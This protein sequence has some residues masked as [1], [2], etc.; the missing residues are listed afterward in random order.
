MKTKVKENNQQGRLRIAR[1]LWPLIVLVFSLAPPAS[2]G[3]QFWTVNGP[4]GG[5]IEALA[6][7]PQNPQVLYAGGPAGVYK[8]TSAGERWERVKGNIGVQALAIDP[9]TSQ[10][11]YAGGGGIWRS[12][13]GGSTW[14][15]ASTGLTNTNIWALVVDPVN[16]QNLYAGTF[17]GG[18]FKSIDQ[19][20]SWAAI[21]NGLPAQS[22]IALAIDPAN[23]QNLY[24]GTLC[25]G[26][27]RSADGGASWNSV[28]GPGLAGK[29][30]HALEMD[31]LSPQVVYAGTSEGTVYKSADSGST[32]TQL[33]TAGLGL[34]NLYALAVDPANSSTLYLASGG[35]GIYK[36]TD[37]GASW[38]GMSAGIINTNTYA[39]AL[40]PA[41]QQ[42]I[43]TSTLGAGIFKSTDGAGSWQAAN[44]GINNATVRSLVAQP[45]TSGILYASSFGGVAKSTDGGGSWSGA[46][47]GLEGGVFFSLAIDP[48]H[49]Q[50]LY[51]GA[52][53]A[54]AP[55][56]KTTDGGNTWSPTG[57]GA[58]WGSSASPRALAVDPINP[59]VV[60]AGGWGSLFK[61]VDGG[62][63]WAASSSGIPL[64]GTYVS[65]LAVDPANPQ[66]LY[67]GLGDGG[68]GATIAN[69]GAY[70]SLDGGNTWAPLTGLPATGVNALI[71]DPL[72]T[73]ILYAG[74]GDA[75]H[76]PRGVYRSSDGGATWS[77]CSAGLT[78]SVVRALAIDPANPQ[79]LYAGGGGVFMSKDRGITWT[80]LS[81]GLTN[82]DIRTLTVDPGHPQTVYAGT[83]GGGVFAITL[84]EPPA[85]TP[86]TLADTPWPM[87]GHDLQHTGRSPFKGP[88]NP[89]IA[90]CFKTGAEVFSSPA[91]GSDGSIYVGS[92]DG[93]LY[94]LNPDGSRQWAYA[95]GGWVDSSPAIGSDGSIYV[96]SA[97]N[98][99][100]L[101][102]NGAPVWTSPA[103]V[104]LSSPALSR[105]GALYV[106]GSDVY[107]I[108]TSGVSK[109]RFQA[110]REFT[111]SPAV[112]SDGTVYVGTEGGTLLALNPD[113]SEKWR[114]TVSQAFN[115]SPALTDDGTV[116]VGS[117]DGGLYALNGD[118]T[119]KW[120]FAAN[121]G[122]F[123]SPA[124]GS[125]G[126]IYVGAGGLFAI[127]PAG[128]LKW[129][130]PTGGAT[131]S[132][133][134]ID[135]EGTVYIGGADGVYAV[136][137]DGSLKWRLP[138][139]A[140]LRSSPAIGSDGLLYV[141]A[142]DGSFYA[143][144]SGPRL[145]PVLALSLGA[146][147]TLR[148][149]EVQVGQRAVRQ[150]TVSNTGNDTLV[151]W[152]VISSDPAFGT[153]PGSFKLGP[154][155]SQ[156]LE[157]WFS[158][159]ESGKKT[160]V[161]T[162]SHNAQDGSAQ[163]AL[164]GAGSAP[165]LPP[166]QAYLQWLSQ[167]GPRSINKGSY[168]NAAQ[169][170]PNGQ[171]A[172][173]RAWDFGNT[174]MY[175]VG[176][177][178][179]KP[180]SGNP[181]PE[182][183]KVTVTLTHTG[184]GTGCSSINLWRP[185]TTVL[186]ACDPSSSGTRT[187]ELMTN[188]DYRIETNA[189]A[190]SRDGGKVEYQSVL[191]LDLPAPPL[192]PLPTFAVAPQALS[193]GDTEV[194]RT[195]QRQFVI[196]NTSSVVL[197]VY[198]MS[199]DSDQFRL[200]SSS[201]G[202]TINPG[203]SAVV[204]VAFA[205]TSEGSKRGVLSFTT[206]TV[207]SPDPLPTT[208]I[209]LS[210]NGVLPAVPRASFSPAPSAS[211]DFGSIRVGES[212]TI[213]LSVSN[214]GTAPLHILS[215]NM[216]GNDKGM[217]AL[218]LPSSTIPPGG[219]D[220]VQVTFFPSA[221]GQRS[222]TLSIV[223]DAPD[224]PANFALVGVGT[225]SPAPEMQLNPALLALGNVALGHSGQGWFTIT[226]AG[227]SPL[228]VSA[229]TADD[230]AFVPQPASFTLG[231]G[232][233]QTVVVTFTPT[234]RG[235]RTAALTVVHNA[236]SSPTMLSV[237]GKGVGPVL[238][239]SAQSLGFGETLLNTTA[240]QLLSFTNSGDADLQVTNIVSSDPA[241][242]V[243]L[244]SFTVSSGNTQP[245][246]VSFRPPAAGPRTAT[247]GITHNASNSPAS[248]PLIGTGV[249]GP[250][251]SMPA[252]LVMAETAVG[253]STQAEFVV[254]NTGGGGADDQRGFHRRSEQ[255]AVQGGAEHRP[256]SGRRQPGLRGDLLPLLCGVQGRHTHPHAQ[257]GSW[258]L[259]DQSERKRGETRPCQ[260]TA[261]PCFV[262]FAGHGQDPPGRFLPEDPGGQQSRR[263]GTH[264]LR[265]RDER[266][267]CGPVPG[268]AGHCGRS[269]RRQPDLHSDFCTCLAGGQDRYPFLHPQCP[270]ESDACATERRLQP[271][272][273]HQCADQWVGHGQHPDQNDL[274]ENLHRHQYW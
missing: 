2:A 161:L 236:G 175:T 55:V 124:I 229:I 170:Y 26:V 47:Q 246:V 225:I 227:G 110:G 157:V 187:V 222:A 141:G 163:I 215:A 43:Y 86:V 207:R 129:H 61:S 11:L 274:A 150:F 137:A 228:V 238:T 210:G 65:A 51:A 148:F 162:I 196:K 177:F 91:I 79:V 273:G 272:A 169:Y 98:L 103:S 152:S 67:A 248:L 41:N 195:A 92:Q 214:T 13:D 255:P 223:H 242:A 3:E 206:G 258:D 144:K 39:L 166:P 205:P 46:S 159:V 101:S 147:D 185:Y 122:V 136:K 230:P 126:T 95:T 158:P 52:D 181:T 164:S 133:P 171:M 247:L 88:D 149:G 83:E 241:F 96:G 40:D 128:G 37:G 74:L 82:T 38:T 263:R 204:S 245:V 44:S 132:S 270:G 113:G 119:L 60:Y 221:A 66:T 35:K 90:W 259:Q 140:P 192:P 191:T 22:V 219:T 199:I 9:L 112:G 28:G 167:D 268:R 109:W 267:G 213:S 143:L 212:R 30:V 105:E 243:S 19:G 54:S 173:V 165:P 17:G 80:E 62:G 34:Y 160:A 32:W 154:G 70:K 186:E 174:T 116:Y 71:I 190:Y 4:G 265:H 5:R 64:G 50:V 49:P 235:E 72:N 224:S 78:R 53:H 73:Q 8:S 271:G 25:D 24:A 269:G 202:Q 100:S 120:R 33:P 7:D 201:G 251:A 108:T 249:A 89:Q 111:A 104:G 94:A 254:T 200:V 178:M 264:H 59:Q 233:V 250:Q 226:N 252:S 172:Q 262:R 138:L 69:V 18:V 155:N 134:A 63:S 218:T 81:A 31:Q 85:P 68:T 107:A 75:N 118:G 10:T 127:A 6:V 130:Y 176:H 180:L 20:N 168:E 87:R 257:R 209:P 117:L 42:T 183:V 193:F 45:G 194:G 256:D 57:S 197:P 106:A 58:G 239:L 253:T 16:P 182:P 76:G 102:R 21:V 36:S 179:V 97:G 99:H 266:A 260:S 189:Q 217:F 142:M 184:S 244:T 151:V 12:T 216:A 135:S 156:Q 56:F 131:Q 146:M 125:D 114:F 232:Q 203:D 188:T 198:S 93:Y 211:L 231:A 237:S 29:Y 123:S 220:A 121:A 145:A 261:D 23:P 48:L 208:T 234:A 115:S 84:P 77:D 27:H 1:N 139:S 15:A 14:T 153:N 240:T